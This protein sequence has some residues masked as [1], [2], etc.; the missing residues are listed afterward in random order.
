M[1]V[2]PRRA[3]TTTRTPKNRTR[4]RAVG[5]PHD[6]VH[7]KHAA[8]PGVAAPPIPTTAPALPR[9]HRR[10]GALRACLS[11]ALLRCAL[12]LAP[13]SVGVAGSGTLR[14]VAWPVP[15]VTLLLGWTAAQALTCAGA[16][17]ARRAGPAVACRLVG[18][19]FAAVAGLWCALVW[20]APDPMVGPQRGLALVVGLSGLATLATITAALVTRSEA[21][22]VRWSMPSW[23][24]GAATVAALA[25][26]PVPWLPVGTLLPAAIVLP[27]VRAFRPAM[28]PGN[29]RRKFALTGPERQRSFRYLV[30]GAS[31]AICVVLLWQGGPSGSTVPFWLPLLLAVP[32]LEALIAWNIGQFGAR[33]RGVT[34]VTL[35]GLLPPLVLGCGLAVAGFTGAPAGVLA[36]AGGTLLSG[37]FAITFLLGARGRTGIAAVLAAAPP[38]AVAV[39]KLLPLPAA[40]PLPNAVGALAVT[41]AA[42]LLVVALTAADHRRTS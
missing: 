37:V 32:I 10:P 1:T 36:L 34:L 9:N 31:Q 23:V 29:P 11:A 27:L 4:R 15:L 38:V 5:H 13:I 3:A 35:T 30:I 28:M 14:H 7:A 16:A 40:G 2:K 6:G 8:E 39:L 17:V 33:P 12:Y 18:G 42:G 26:N 21:A 19:G 24:L 20:I 25:G 41:H 22:A